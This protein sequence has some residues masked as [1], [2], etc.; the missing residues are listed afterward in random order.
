MDFYHQ[1]IGPNRYS[2]HSQGGYELPL[3]DSMAWINYHGQVGL[4]FKHRD[5]A[6]IKRVS[7]F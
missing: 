3:A 4:I 1:A 6:D 7:K 2:G 5:C